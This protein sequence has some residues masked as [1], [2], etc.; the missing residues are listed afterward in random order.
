MSEENVQYIPA[1]KSYSGFSDYQKEKR[2]CC[3]CGFIH[4][5]WVK[6]G[7]YYCPWTPYKDTG[8]PIEIFDY[9]GVAPDKI[10]THFP[11]MGVVFRRRIE[12]ILPQIMKAFAANKSEQQQAKS[13]RRSVAKERLNDLESR[14]FWIEAEM[15]SLRLENQQLASENQRLQGEINALHQNTNQAGMIAV[16]AANILGRLDDNINYIAGQMT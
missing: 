7:L 13:Q 1:H 15:N 6:S 5:L 12:K 11:K 14:L 16:R 10:F 9:L 4:T 8:Y 3:H 2:L